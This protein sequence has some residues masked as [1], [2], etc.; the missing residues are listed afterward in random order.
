MNPVRIGKTTNSNGVEV[1][2]VELFGVPLASS[3]AL[4]D[5]FDREE[6]F[7]E[8]WTDYF[9]FMLVSMLAER[10]HAERGPKGWLMATRLSPIPPRLP[11]GGEEI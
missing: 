1:V 10:M 4:V 6:D 2:V 11:R 5:S 8:R 7:V 3:A 9:T